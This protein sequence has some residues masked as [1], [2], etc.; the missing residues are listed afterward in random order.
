[1]W[2]I[3]GTLA[4]REWVL[5][6]AFGSFHTRLV[7]ST[8]ES[9]HSQLELNRRLIRLQVLNGVPVASEVKTLIPAPST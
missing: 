3:I 5:V 6:V 7:Y 4:L 2:V 9:L 1:M 8:G